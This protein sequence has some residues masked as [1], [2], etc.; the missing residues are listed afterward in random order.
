MHA[1]GTLSEDTISLFLQQIAAAINVIHRNNIVHR[2]LKPQN[3]LISEIGEL[4][5]ADFGL[6]RAQSV[7]SHT[8]SSEVVTLWYRPPEVLLGS[9]HYSSPLGDNRKWNSTEIS[10]FISISI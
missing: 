4:K 5:L 6:A 7:P 10:N 3:L 9:T 2:D 8:F 1:K